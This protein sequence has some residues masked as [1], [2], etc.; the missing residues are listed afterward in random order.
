MFN[1]IKKVR[2]VWIHGDQLTK[3]ITVIGMV[4]VSAKLSKA[5]CKNPLIYEL[6]FKVNDDL[7]SSLI[8]KFNK[9]GVTIM[10]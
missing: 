2:K 8:R 5:D 10:N 7:Y 6:S 4:G 1:K 3:A 9:Y